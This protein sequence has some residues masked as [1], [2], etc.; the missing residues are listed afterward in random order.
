MNKKSFFFII[1]LLF[2]ISIITSNYVQA[3]NS[4][5]KVGLYPYVPRIEQFKTALLNEWKIKNPTVNLIFDETWDGGYDTKPSDD[6][7]VF[8]FDA[9]NFANFLSN[10]YLMSM[11]KVDINNIDDFVPYAIEGV[12]YNDS[13]YAIP[14]LGC[15]NILFYKKTDTSVGNAKSIDQLNSALN[16]CTYTSQIPPD[17]RGLML[18]M[19]GGTT[20]ATFYLDIAH[21][22]NNK[23]PL[24]LPNHDSDL[25]TE[26]IE[27]MHDLLSMASFENATKSIKS[28]ERAVWFSNGYGRAL[29]GFTEHMSAMTKETRDSINFKPLP[30]SN[31]NN[32]P[33]FYADVIAVNAKTKNRELALQLANIMASTKVMVESIGADKKSVYP[34]YL[35]STRQSVFKEIGKNFPIYNKMLTMVQ[36]YNPIMFKLPA[37]SEEWLKNMKNDIRTRAQANYTCGCDRVSSVIISSYI[38]A[39]NICTATCANYGGWNKQWTNETPA[40]PL[41]KSVCGC[42]SCAN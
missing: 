36:E 41:G 28:Y 4:S 31:N 6:L 13:Y 37:N 24:P 38:T 12:K 7:D 26:V 3:A 2:I 25:S 17:K 11:K 18:D 19:S 20:N 1:K 40:A 32:P 30:M 39:N 5:L 8:V 27:S 14:Q 23:Y 29:I 33:L 35:M 21:S 10:G 9:M 34:Q 15:A 42:N 22:M 16:Q